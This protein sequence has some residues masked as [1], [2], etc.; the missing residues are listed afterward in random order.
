MEVKNI[1]IDNPGLLVETL[2]RE[3]IN[4]NTSYVVITNDDNIE[5]HFKNYIYRVHKISKIIDPSAFL[6]FSD[7]F[8][9]D[10]E[11][12]H[13]FKKQRPSFKRYT[14]NDIKKDNKNNK[15]TKSIKRNFSKHY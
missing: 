8:S 10:S 11:I 1:Y 6:N 14:K 4:E 12:S 15:M 9:E 5:I 2:I 13:S 7:S 3:C